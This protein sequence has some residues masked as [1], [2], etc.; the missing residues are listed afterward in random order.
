MSQTSM[1]DELCPVTGEPI[2]AYDNVR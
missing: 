1:Q 2:V